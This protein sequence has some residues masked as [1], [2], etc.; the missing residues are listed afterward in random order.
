MLYFASTLVQAWVNYKLLS[1]RRI[2]IYIL[3]SNM[4]YFIYV[5]IPFLVEIGQITSPEKGAGPI[6]FNQYVINEHNIVYTN[7]VVFIGILIIAIGTTYSPSKKTF[8]LGINRDDLYKS[9]LLAILFSSLAYGVVI[10]SAGGLVKLLSISEALRGGDRVLRTGF[11]FY[12]AKLAWPASVILFGKIVSDRSRMHNV[13][14][15]DRALLLYSVVLTLL[16]LLSLAGRAMVVMYLGSFAFLYYIRDKKIYISYFMYILIFTIV[17][18]TYGDY[19]FRLFADQ[20]GISSRTELILRGGLF[21]IVQDVLR[22]FIF[23]YTNLLI[24]IGDVKSLV[25]VHLLE[26]PKAIVNSL[27][28]GAIGIPD[29]ATLSE[30]TTSKYGTEAEIPADLLSFGYYTFGVLGVVLATFLYAVFFRNLDFRLGQLDDEVYHAVH[31][32]LACK[33]CF[34]AMYADLHQVLIGNIHFLIF[35]VFAFLCK[36]VRTLNLQSIPD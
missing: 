24:A 16:V 33:L 36:E 1:S 32:L 7:I 20:G 15:I 30:H 8:E 18:I 6:I 11:L 23:P 31:S 25:D 3:F 21:F 34:I 13:N 17:F 26:F 19:I 29:L 5:L 35:A 9:A 10:A 22:E 4:Y 14:L 27:P 12:F 28:G 2:G